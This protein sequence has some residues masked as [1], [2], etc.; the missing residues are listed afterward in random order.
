MKKSHETRPKVPRFRKT[1]SEPQKRQAAAK[2]I[3]EPRVNADNAKVHLES[4]WSVA[5]EIGGTYH[6]TKGRWAKWIY[7]QWIYGLMCSPLVLN[8]G[9]S[10]LKSPSIFVKSQCPLVKTQSVGKN[11]FAWWKLKLLG[12]SEFVCHHLV[13]KAQWGWSR[14]NASWPV[15]WVNWVNGQEV[16]LKKS[17]PGLF[18]SSTQVMSHQFF[19]CIMFW[20]EASCHPKLELEIRAPRRSSISQ[21]RFL[22]YGRNP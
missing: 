2:L 15:R 10:M 9:Q 1:R 3:R 7:L 20:Y 17:A 19:G 18:T 13:A 8:V 14:V 4:Q 22:D 16:E 5:T 12:A 21:L 11:H 6:W